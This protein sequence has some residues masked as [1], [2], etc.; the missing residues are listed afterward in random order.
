[1]EDILK[2]LLEEKKNIEL[3]LRSRY[4][5]SSEIDRDVGDEVDF[6]VVEQERELNLL[7]KDREKVHLEAIEEALQRIE[8][9]EYGFCEEC[10]DIIN[11]KRLLVMPLAQYCINCQQNQERSDS[12]YLSSGFTQDNYSMRD[13]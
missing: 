4:E 10:G 13:D 6:S 5:E 3:E 7:L 9:G 2:L 1:M 8:T 12:S 11:K